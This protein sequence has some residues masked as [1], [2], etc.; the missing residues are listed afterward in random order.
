MYA[1]F[2]EILIKLGDARGV[3]LINGRMV[4]ITYSGASVDTSEAIDREDL[5]EPGDHRTALASYVRVT[6]RWGQVVAD[7][8]RK[9]R[10][11]GK[12][13]AVDGG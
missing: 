13:H 8:I 10:S 1:F 4:D 9:V 12:P 11:H 3:G 7:Q 6:G 5:C 2:P